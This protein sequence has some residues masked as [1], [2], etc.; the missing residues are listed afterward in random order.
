LTKN[1]NKVKVIIKTSLI[2]IPE[3]QNYYWE[4]FTKGFEEQ[5]WVTR[6]SLNKS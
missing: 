6:W 3:A 1:M 5:I 4:E 2:T